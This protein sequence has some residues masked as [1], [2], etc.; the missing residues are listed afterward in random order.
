MVALWNALMGMKLRCLKSYNDSPDFR[1]LYCNLK[2]DE[3]AGIRYNINSKPNA[4]PKKSH[5]TPEK[6]YLNMEER[7]EL[8]IRR[9]FNWTV[10]RVVGNSKLAQP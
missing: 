2:I 5:R 3:L 1:K 9:F 6:E 4:I 8:N 7:P 10:L